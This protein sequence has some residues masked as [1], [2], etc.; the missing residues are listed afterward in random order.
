MKRITANKTTKLKVASTTIALAMLTGSN[1]AMA[2]PQIPEMS[3]CQGVISAVTSQIKAA[4]KLYN[5]QDIN[6]V[7]KGLA[8]YDNF[9]TTS[10]ID[11]QLLKASNGNQSKIA[12]LQL[13]VERYKNLATLKYQNYYTDKKMHMDFAVALNNCTKIAAPAGSDLESLKA[14]LLKIVELAKRK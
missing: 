13:Q 6:T 8:V 5:Q 3:T 10:I 1:I 2:R 7:V 12:K 14:S 11:P 9:I 4:D